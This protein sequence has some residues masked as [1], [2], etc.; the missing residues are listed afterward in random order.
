MIKNTRLRLK[1]QSQVAEI[2]PRT[3]NIF[4]P[5]IAFHIETSHLICSANQMT[6][7]YMK[8]NTELK[9]VKSAKF[10]LKKIA[11]YSVIFQRHMFYKFCMW[12]CLGFHLRIPVKTFSNELVYLNSKGFVPR[13]VSPKHLI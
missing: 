2:F 12:H 9:W 10:T 11:D 1:D 5:S 13:R 7:F 3:V 6:G 4:Q 8:C